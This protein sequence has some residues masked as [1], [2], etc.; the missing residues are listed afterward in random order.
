M[1]MLNY[2]RVMPVLLKC[3]IFSP[4]TTCNLFIRSHFGTSL[5][6]VFSE[7]QCLICLEY[8]LLTFFRTYCGKIAS[9]VNATS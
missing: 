5:I 3:L 7:C 6:D 4:L 8:S 9:R 1:A 2:Q